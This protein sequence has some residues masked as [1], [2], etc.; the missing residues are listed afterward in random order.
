MRA[1]REAGPGIWRSFRRNLRCRLFP[2]GRPIRQPWHLAVHPGHLS[3]H[4]R[5]S[6]G[7]R[8]A[9]GRATRLVGKDA[10]SGRLVPSGFRFGSGG[11]S[12]SAWRF[13]ELVSCQVRGLEGSMPKQSLPR[14]MWGLDGA[15]SDDCAPLAASAVRLGLV[16]RPFL[17]VFRHC[18]RASLPPRLV[19]SFPCNFR[20]LFLTL[21]VGLNLSTPEGCA[22][23]PSRARGFW[24]IIFGSP[25]MR[26][27]SRWIVR[28]QAV[29]IRQ[30]LP[31][32]GRW[33]GSYR[34]RAASRRSRRA[35]RRMKPAA[36]FW[37]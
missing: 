20:G 19:N 32:Q 28:G 25:Q 31:L 15:S 30:L 11:A 22:R 3:S 6:A 1:V 16:R 18:S 9:W 27:T 7:C 10:A 4:P 5:G 35:F 14:V 2:P 13:Q 34:S 17:L 23:H 21:R 29:E 36:S 12:P 8:K 33:Q 37:S 26:W 24:G